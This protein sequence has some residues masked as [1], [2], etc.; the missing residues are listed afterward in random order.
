[1][2]VQPSE[3]PGIT[4]KDNDIDIKKREQRFGDKPQGFVEREVL[5]GSFQFKTTNISVTWGTSR[6]TG[7]PDCYSF[8]TT[9]YVLENTGDNRLG[10]GF[11][12]RD[13][14]MGRWPLSGRGCCEK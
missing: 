8:R 3:F 9:M 14:V 13:V 7:C 10:A 11:R 6:R 1:L 12:E 5:I 4:D 2:Q